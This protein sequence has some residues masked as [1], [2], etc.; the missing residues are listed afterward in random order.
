MSWPI[1]LYRVAGESM[2]PT[3]KPGDTLIGLRW[4]RPKP[5]LVVV[6]M[7]NGK[8]LIKRLVSLQDDHIVIQGDNSPHSTDSR[9]FG[10][11]PISQLKAKIIAKL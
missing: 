9:H 10:P 4:F 11:I 1:G 2:A 5:G 6:A 8:P 3:Y 7:H